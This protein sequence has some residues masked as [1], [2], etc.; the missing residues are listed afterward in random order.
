M[1]TQNEIVGLLKIASAY[2]GRERG[3][4]DIM[5]WGDA[6]TRAEWTYAE[7][8]EALKDHFAFDGAFLTP[9]TVTKRL[10]AA[11][12]AAETARLQEIGQARRAELES[13]QANSPARAE[14]IRSAVDNL[15]GRLGWQRKPNPHQAALRA[16]CPH[17]HAAPGL[18][19]ARQI[20]RGHRQGEYVPL[21]KPHPA[22]EA[23][24]GTFS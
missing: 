10:T 2:D 23:T 6:A 7:A 3:Q 11:R 4:A 18:P 21:S 13:G 8:A 20:A 24:G 12:E 17:C 16:E 19:C 5:A 15:A 1:M 9:A 22:R 14:T